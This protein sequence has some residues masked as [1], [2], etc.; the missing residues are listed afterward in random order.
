[1]S[2]FQVP[3]NQQADF[4]P[5]N[6]VNANFELASAGKYLVSTY[7]C[8]KRNRYCLR[9]ILTSYKVYMALKKEFSLSMDKKSAFL[10]IQLFKD[11]TIWE[12]TARIF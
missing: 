1:M 4:E 3:Q 10:R 11:S 7:F 9:I 2:D 8:N 5:K 12:L 6:E